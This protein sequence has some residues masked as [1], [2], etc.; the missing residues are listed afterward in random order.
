MKYAFS[1]NKHFIRLK[2]FTV[3][4]QLKRSDPF[5]L[6][7]SSL[8]SWILLVGKHL[9]TMKIQDTLD[10]EDQDKPMVFFFFF[11]AQVL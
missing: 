11:F 1:K 4:L 5:H 9:M 7:F 10:L 6:T 2:G 3:D 8:L